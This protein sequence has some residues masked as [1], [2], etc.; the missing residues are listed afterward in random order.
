MRMILAVILM[1]TMGSAFAAPPSTNLLFILTDNQPAAILG[2]YGNSDVRTPHIDRLAAEG[3]RFSNAFAVNGMCSPT[4]ATLMTG[5][6]PS[7]HGVHNWLDDELM[8]DWPRDW[9][10]IAEFRTLPLTLANRGYQTAMIGKWHLGQPWQPSLGF[11][12][13]VTFTDGHT[14]DFWDNTIIDNGDVYPVKGKH[15]VDFFAD[16]AVEFLEGRKAGS[17]FYLQLNLNGPYLNP[18]SNLGPARNRHY[19]DYAGQEFP[20]FPRVA[21]NA[22]VAGQLVDSTTPPFLIKKHLQAIAMHNDPATMANVA[23]QNTV[24]DDAVGR[25]LAALEASGQAD[26]TLVIFSTDQGN[27]FGQHGLWQHTVVTSPANLY[28]A[29]MNIPLIVR[30]PGKIRP[31]SKDAR[32]IGQYDI[33]VTILD[34]LGIEIALDN[35]PGRSFAPLLRGEKNAWRDEVFYEQEE[36]R[37]IRT[38]DY[39]Y[40]KRLG[41]TWPDELY[42]MQN[43]P[44]QHKNLIDDPAQASTI[45]ALDA[46]LEAFFDRYADSQYDLWRGGIAKGSVVRPGMFRKLYGPDWRPRTDLKTPFSE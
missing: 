8:E 39:A 24:V 7:Q 6:L 45:S 43:D 28:E 21:F 1:V 14:V 9:S 29:A 18:P 31:G 41:D 2:A 30:H 27:F 26:S 4:R 23:S 16:K 34:Y 12:H 40:W 20:S 33:P 19:E 17:P 42:D 25:V 37:G 3:V 11:Q 13:W 38:A 10:A 35:S 46:R 22:N 5:L 36:S 15:T 32:L 44:G